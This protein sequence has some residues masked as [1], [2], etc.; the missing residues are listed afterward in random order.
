MLELTL[1]IVIE[2]IHLNKNMVKEKGN[3]I[4]EQYALIIYNIIQKIVKSTK[5]KKSI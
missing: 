1:L 4:D 5:D 3:K 2:I